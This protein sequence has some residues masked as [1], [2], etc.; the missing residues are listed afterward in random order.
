MSTPRYYVSPESTLKQF[1]LDETHIL[2]KTIVVAAG[3]G[4][5]EAGTAL[6]MVTA[7]GKYKPYNNANTDGTE[8]CR[9]LLMHKVDATSADQTATLL[10]HGY[11]KESEC[12][13]VDAAAKADLPL[14]VFE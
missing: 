6:G 11:V 5:L 1:L 13:G 12:T 10:F 4:V 8:V 3:A 9:G 7:T 14:I 2:S